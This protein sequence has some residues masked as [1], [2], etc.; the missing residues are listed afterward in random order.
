MTTRRNTYDN[1]ESKRQ[2][3]E[4]EHISNAVI[5]GLGNLYGVELRVSVPN[6]P[7]ETQRTNVHIG[8]VGTRLTGEINTKKMSRNEKKTAEARVINQLMEFIIQ[9]DPNISYHQTKA[10]PSQKTEKLYKYKAIDPFNEV[11]F[12]VFGE[13]MIELMEE[14]AKEKVNVIKENGKQT[15]IE[16][17]ASNPMILDIYQEMLLDMSFL[18]QKGQLLSMQYQTQMMTIQQSDYAYS[19]EN[20]NGISDNYHQNEVINYQMF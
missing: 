2:S 12:R 13:R 15:T 14:M 4:R 20:M 11:G 18:S 19:N 16:L 9:Q 3:A 1:T 10:R 17:F 6:S 8:I 5:I 7:K